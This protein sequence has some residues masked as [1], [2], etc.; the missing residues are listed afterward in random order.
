MTDDWILRHGLILFVQNYEPCIAF[1]RDTL[2]LRVLR[3]QDDL[4]ILGFGDGY[5]MIEREGVAHPEKS[6]AQNPTVLRFNVADVEASAAMLRERGVEVAVHTYE[7][8]TVGRFR[9]PDGNA[10]ALRN[11]YDGFFAPVRN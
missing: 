8:G 10:C 9:D 7:W 6:V 11:H 2:G 5:L 4:V 3:E 1:Y